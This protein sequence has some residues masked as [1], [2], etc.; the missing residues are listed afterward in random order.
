M[1]VDNVCLIQ[2][3]IEVDLDVKPGSA[4]NTINIGSK[5]LI[6]VAILGSDDL[7]V[8]TIDVSSILL[9]DGSSTGTG[10]NVKKNGTYQYSIEDVD[11]DGDMDLVMHFSTTALVA[12]GDLSSASTSL[13]VTGMNLDGVLIIG[14]DTITIVPNG[15]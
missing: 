2:N 14:D 5:G 13:D 4:S 1:G 9:G 7:D 10:V 12:N 15:N 11:G 3:A 8:T 6:P